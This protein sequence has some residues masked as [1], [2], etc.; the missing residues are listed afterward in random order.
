LTAIALALAPHSAKCPNGGNDAK[1]AHRAKPDRA[2]SGK[3]RLR[4]GWQLHCRSCCS[5]HTERTE[6]GRARPIERERYRYEQEPNVGGDEHGH[7][8][9]RG[10]QLR[11]GARP[12]RQLATQAEVDPVERSLYIGDL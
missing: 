7:T 2:E 1:D 8:D 9:K 5:H 11:R 10:D 4:I 6:C 3:H 12:R